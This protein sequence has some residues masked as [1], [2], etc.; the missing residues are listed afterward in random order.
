MQQ[1][2]MQQQQ[3]QQQQMQQQQMQAPTQGVTSQFPVTTTTLAVP[4]Q[5]VQTPGPQAAAYSCVCPPAAGQPQMMAAQ[6]Q[7]MAVQPQLVY[8]TPT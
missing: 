8:T 2:Q 5:T 4:V 3:M 1:Q 7:M 6:P